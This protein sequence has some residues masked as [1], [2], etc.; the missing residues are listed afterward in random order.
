MKQLLFILMFP[1]A[2]WGQSTLHYEGVVQVDSAMSKD[3]IYNKTVEWVSET[4]RSANN[5]IQNKDKDA[6]VVQLNA[7]YSC[8]TKKV[9][10]HQYYFDVRYSLKVEMKDGRYRYEFTNFIPQR[11]GKTY[12]PLTN[13]DL[14]GDM[15]WVMEK[16]EWEALKVSAAAKQAELVAAL[17]AKV[18]AAP[19]K[20]DW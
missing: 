2:S 4:Y 8:P 17:T 5:V 11:D 16:R 10:G 9:L 14:P 12:S 13:G 15:T 19:A 1:L 7:I 3:A 18:N 20:S 6:G